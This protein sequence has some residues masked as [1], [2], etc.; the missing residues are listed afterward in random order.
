MTC[1]SVRQLLPLHAGGDLDEQDSGQIDAHLDS[2][3]A[4]SAFAAEYAEAR[5]ALRRLDP[6]ELD[7]SV[8]AGMRGAV[9]REIRKQPAA[10][11]A[12]WWN[13]RWAAAAALV[14]AMSPLAL[15]LS[16]RDARD[17]H[18]VASVASP[19]PMTPL[20]AVVSPPP[21]IERREAPTV[22]R[23]A[24]RRKKTV[25]EKV[26]DPLRLEIQT[27]DPNIRIIWFATAT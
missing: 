21:P 24:P 1:E 19:A 13:S 23:T 9:L 26:S 16:G 3:A 10:V 5:N 11:R 7:A 8:Y 27:Q 20:P 2:C 14:I 6:P 25:P 4:C 12:G 17:A 15:Y 22:A 18:P